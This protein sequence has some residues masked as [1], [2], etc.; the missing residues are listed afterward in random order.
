M[1]LIPRLAV[2]LSLLALPAGAA[3]ASPPDETTLGEIPVAV[4]GAEHVVKLAVLPSLA[5]DLEDVVVRGVVRR[6]LEI[7]G[8]FALV[9]ESLAP[10]GA[11]G[12]DDPVDV[13]AWRA[14]GAEVAVKVAARKNAEGTVD[15]VG[16]AYLL[17]HGADPVYQKRLTVPA[18]DLRLTAHRLTDAL[19]GALT[20]RPGSFASRLAYTAPW[21]RARRVL[22]L[23]ADGHDLK[24]VSPETATAVAPAFAP[25]ARL[26]YSMSERYAPF[27]LH[28]D[29]HPPERVT[30]PFQ[31]SVYA[32]AFD[33][34]GTKLAVA[35]AEPGGSA[36]HV[37]NAD[38]TGMQ[39]VSTTEVAIHP[40]WSPSGKL[41]WV[42][43]GGRQGT[44]RVYL[45]GKAVSPAG[46]AASSPTFCDTADGIRLVFAVAIGGD[47]QDLVMTT[48]RGGGVTRLT[49]NQGSNTHPACSPDGRLLAFF[50]TRKGAAGPGLYVLSL[51]R[52]TSS[53]LSSQLGESLRWAALPAAP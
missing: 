28:R 15:V 4:T 9:P 45:D 34:T 26:H 40:V 7:S 11:Y 33:R 23:D 21:G 2:A 46:F 47:R 30:L 27:A 22:A 48:E 8:L 14:A 25:G 3:P 18:A 31:E 32:A 38:G 17:R 13:P 51:E 53:R 10:A 19:L 29:G 43:G 6:D 50:S 42:G 39:R 16:L 44:Q 41:A 20:G 1:R 37:G 36:I 5:P 24:P 35:V 49:Q 12:F 52:W